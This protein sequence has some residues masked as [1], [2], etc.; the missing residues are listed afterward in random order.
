M[1][2]LPV[3]PRAPAIYQPTLD[4]WPDLRAGRIK[5]APVRVGVSDGRGV[6]P[7][8]G[9]PYAGQ[10]IIGWDH[11]VQCIAKI[12]VTR[13][14]ER[15]LRYWV[16]CFLPHILGKNANRFTIP[17]FYWAIVTA[18]DLWEPNYRIQRVLMQHRDNGAAAS[19]LAA[20]AE[21]QSLTSAEEMR[22]G[23]M[24][25][26]MDGVYRPRAH[27]GDDTPEV[28]RSLGLIGR[29]TGP[30]NRANRLIA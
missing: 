22:R 27:L 3:D 6:N 25:C 11:V 24:T 20:S 21:A 29:G 2:T 14:H 16:G 12:F 26:A 1:A 28:R 30:W 5:L 17:R 13:F 19:S 23:V 15:V 9:K 7:E 4:I 8:T 10:I 18:I